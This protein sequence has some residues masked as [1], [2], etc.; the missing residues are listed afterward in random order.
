MEAVFSSA[1][2]FVSLIFFHLLSQIA[3]P[4]SGERHAA[5]SQGRA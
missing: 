2:V 4:S 1:L 3:L 5:Y